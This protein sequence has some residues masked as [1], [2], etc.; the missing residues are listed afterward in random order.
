MPKLTSPGN[1]QSKYIH[2]KN[3]YTN[4]F[5]N[6]ERLSH[7]LNPGKI[8]KNYRGRNFPEDKSIHAFLKQYLPS[9]VKP[10]FSRTFQTV[11]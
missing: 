7:I 1:I 6:Q 11:T 8:P 10:I 2:D 5:T 3:R 9:T 4:L